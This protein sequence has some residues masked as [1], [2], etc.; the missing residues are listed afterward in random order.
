MS[1]LEPASA[2]RRTV[3]YVSDDPE[4]ALVR[5]D[6]DGA[7]A[8]EPLPQ[9]E[10]F[11]PSLPTVTGS[12]SD[13]KPSLSTLASAVGPLPEGCSYGYLPKDEDGTEE[14]VI[15][16]DFPAGSKENPFYFP[17]PRKLGI[18]IVAVFYTLLSAYTTSAFSISAGTMC[19][20]LGCTQL[21]VEAGIALY[22]WG[23]A[24]APLFLAPLSEELGRKW[25]YI[26]A[27]IVFWIFHLMMTLGQNT[28]TILISRFILGLSGSLGATL[29]GGTISDIFVPSQRGVPMAAFGFAAIF[30][31]GLG[32]ATMVFVEVDQRLRWRWVWWIQFIIVGVFIPVVAFVMVETRDTVILRRKAKQLRKVRGMTDGARYLARSEVTKVKF[33]VAMRESLLRPLLFL[34]TEPVVM[35][36][37]AWIGLGWGVFYTQIAGLPYMFRHTFG[38]STLAVGQTYWAICVGGILGL[39]INWIQE[40]VYRRQAPKHGVEAR[41]YAPMV[42]GILFFVG[43]FITGFTS[44][45]TVHWIAPLIGVAILL[46]AIMSIYI[47]SFTYLS[48]AYGTWASSAIAAQSFCR[49]VVAGVFT[50]CTTIMFERLTVR[51]ALVMMGGIAAVL[52]LVPFAAFFWGP[53]IRAKSKYSRLCM[54]Q[55]RAK[56][57][58]EKVERE[59]LGIDTSEVEDLEGDA[60]ERP[61]EHHFHHH[62]NHDPERG[63]IKSH[64]SVHSRHSR[65][66]CASLHDVRIGSE[67]A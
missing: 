45:P 38:F 51:W 42:A 50:F 53:Q 25:T 4:P 54:E 43:C 66:E 34:A 1:M 33:S 32:G 19:D 39:G 2:P 46:A 44:I 26:S 56:L 67:K 30:G 49:N 63:S 55:E 47:T 58:H 5:E 6:A 21:E 65:A 41:L 11:S 27:V 31:T 29:V 40:K 35:F 36:F 14:R 52:A 59:V 17:F 3:C 12:F 18:T 13:R 9:E 8:I 20:D 60:N 37:S 61:P 16:V 28:A 7:V 24:F 62:D 64:R 48:E 23:F 22:C 57:E 10:K 15:W